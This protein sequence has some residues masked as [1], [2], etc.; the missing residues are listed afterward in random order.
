[1][2]P[3]H[4]DFTKKNLEDFVR[5]EQNLHFAE[6]SDCLQ[7]QHPFPQKVKVCSFMHLLRTESSRWAEELETVRF[8]QNHNVSRFSYRKIFPL[9]D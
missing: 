1:M 2:D 6:E 5:Y 4:G 7:N 8:L 9:L 3:D